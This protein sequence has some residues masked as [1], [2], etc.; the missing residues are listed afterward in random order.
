MAGSRLTLVRG[1][2]A[3]TNPWARRVRCWRRWRGGR[4]TTLAAPAPR[5]RLQAGPAGG[6]AEPS[7]A[8]V[9]QRGALVRRD[10]RPDER[11]PAPAVEGQVGGPVAPGVRMLQVSGTPEPSRRPAR[12]QHKHMARAGRPPASS[13]VPLDQAHPEHDLQAGGEAAA[14]PRNAA[15][16]R[17]GRDGRRGF[18]SAGGHAAGRVWAASGRAAV[19]PGAPRR[20]QHAV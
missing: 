1:A 20:L 6:K 8:G 4:P 7:G 10:E 17:G 9:Q 12:V 16:G 19:R 5:C 3:G 11:R 15:P 2:G 18:S 13:A 14:L